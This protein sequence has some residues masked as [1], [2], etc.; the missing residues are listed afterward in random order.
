M[1]EQTIEAGKVAA[2]HYTLTNDD[3]KV[4]DTS[5]GRGPLAYLHGHGN[6][7][8]GLERQL[9]GRRGGEQLKVVVPPEEAY[10]P[11]TGDAQAVHRREF[12][13]DAE[14]HEGMPLR[15]TSSDGQEVILWI[16]AIKG[17]QIYVHTDHPLS[18]QTLNFDVEIVEVRDATADELEHGHVHGPGG[19]AH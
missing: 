13:K 14:L 1:S 5:K 8:P 10:G 16:H 7:V 18:G 19:H 6:I 9:A 3:G 17:A 11:R 2:I 12:P 15:A 4:L